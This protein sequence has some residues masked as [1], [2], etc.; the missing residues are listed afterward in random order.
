MMKPL[1]TLEAW[2]PAC[3][4]KRQQDAFLQE[5]LSRIA[6]HSVSSRKQDTAMA[7]RQPLAS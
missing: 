7:T 4:V 6:F 1:L 3:G 5:E 2:E